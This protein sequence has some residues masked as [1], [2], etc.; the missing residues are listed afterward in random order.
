MAVV[1]FESPISLIRME[2]VTSSAPPLRLREVFDAHAPFVWRSLRRL[3]VPTADVDDTLQEVFVVVYQRLAEYQERDRIRSWLYAICVRVAQSQRRKQQRRRESH[4]P[5]QLDP[6]VAPTQLRQVEARE[7]LAFG[8][9]L[10][11]RLP[12]EQREVFVLYEVEH[13]PMAQ[14]AEAVGCRLF[15]AYSRL[16]LARQRVAAELAR[17]RAEGEIV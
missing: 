6:P 4:A 3:G 11:S 8:H 5:E 2:P 10:L 7:A 1:E 12:E 17:A 9:E 14:I 13:M 15:T 16:R